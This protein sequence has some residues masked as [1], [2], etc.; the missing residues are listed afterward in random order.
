[1]SG[2]IKQAATQLLPMVGNFIRPHRS[3][4]LL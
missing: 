3:L 4:N 2:K 1:M